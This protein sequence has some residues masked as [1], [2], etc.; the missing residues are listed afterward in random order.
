M[1]YNVDDKVKVKIGWMLCH[2]TLVEK[3]KDYKW[4]IYIPGMGNGIIYEGD[5]LEKE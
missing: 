5:I 3:L 1:T 2:G 4:V